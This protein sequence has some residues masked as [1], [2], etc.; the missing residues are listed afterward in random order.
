[1]RVS[2]SNLILLA[3]FGLSF[4]LRLFLAFHYP[5]IVDDEGIYSEVGV[6]YFRG[7]LMGNFGAFAVNYEHP[8]LA[9]SHRRLKRNRMTNH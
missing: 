8:A 3:V 6:V 5:R 4:V 1:M 7:L 2:R 9:N